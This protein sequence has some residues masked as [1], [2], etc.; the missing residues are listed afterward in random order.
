MNPS[1]RV[2]IQLLGSDKPVSFKVSGG[3]LIIVR[4]VLTPDDFQLAYVF[5]LSFV[6]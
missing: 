5:K 4:P 1:S 6:P 3:N 2:K